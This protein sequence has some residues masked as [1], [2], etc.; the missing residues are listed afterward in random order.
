MEKEN[1]SF[2]EFIS[3]GLDNWFEVLEEGKNKVKRL[4]PG[5]SERK[6]NKII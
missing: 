3:L 1:I 2:K 5:I 4:V 6:S